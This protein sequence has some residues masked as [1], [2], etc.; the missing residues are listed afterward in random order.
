MKFKLLLHF[1]VPLT[2]T[3]GMIY[4]NLPLYHEILSLNTIWNQDI[5]R[6]ISSVIKYEHIY[7]INV[8][9]HKEKKKFTKK[10]TFMEK[11]R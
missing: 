10:E 2:S 3:N 1:N 6:I 9:I 7:C 4:K 11:K 5:K 8:K